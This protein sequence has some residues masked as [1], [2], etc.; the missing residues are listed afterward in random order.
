MM[1]L[2]AIVA[3]GVFVA[4]EFGPGWRASYAEWQKN[5]P[6]H[7][8][9]S[10]PTALKLPPDAPL[11]KMLRAT[12]FTT[13]SPS[14]RTGIRVYVDPVGLQEAGATMITP[15]TITDSSVPL[16]TALRNALK[17]LKLGYTV[18]DGM[19]VITSL[20]SVLRM[21]GGSEF[22]PPLPVGE[23]VGGADG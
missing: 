13:R 8:A 10:Q 23:G 22:C 4:R 9:L 18:K 16:G 5:R 15:V 2:I 7:A 17:T 19:L 12:V 3:V 6:I 14:F 11:E 20:E 21:F 1:T